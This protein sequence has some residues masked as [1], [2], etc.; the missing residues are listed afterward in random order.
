MKGTFPLHLEFYFLFNTIAQPTSPDATRTVTSD[1]G[2]LFVVVGSG[3]MI[4][5]IGD[6]V[7]SVVAGKVRTGAG[8]N[9]S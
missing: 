3:D 8:G 4:G 7:W 1:G 2:D 9:G 6:A 5:V